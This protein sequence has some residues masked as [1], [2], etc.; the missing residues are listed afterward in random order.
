[1]KG[2]LASV[3][4]LLVFSSA[5]VIESKIDGIQACYLKLYV[6]ARAFYNKPLI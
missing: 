5:E 4:Y 1:M 3:V 2:R 6:Q